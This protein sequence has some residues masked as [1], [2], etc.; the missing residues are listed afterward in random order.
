MTQLSLL[1][2]PGC[3]TLFVIAFL[4]LSCGNKKSSDS[5]CYIFSI[6]IS[7]EGDVSY[8]PE[9]DC[10]RTGD[11]VFISAIPDDGW[12]FYKWTG[13]I[14]FEDGMEYD[15]HIIVTFENENIVLAANFR[16]E[17]LLTIN[18]EPLFG[19]TVEATPDR[20]YY[21]YGD[22]VTLEAT[23]NV[24]YEFSHWLYNDLEIDTN[25]IEI[26]FDFSDEEIT[27]VFNVIE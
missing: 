19:G 27:A 23:P 5:N 25:S 15:S 1:K 26:I 17:L 18:I 8:E 13:N 2:L 14:I 22:T 12:I 11:Q 20:Y 7:G 9:P 10:Y 21:V 6:V 24:G 4:C 3:A 16:E